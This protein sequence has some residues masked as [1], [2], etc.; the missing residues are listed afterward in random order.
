MPIYKMEGKKDGKQKY[1]VRI[2]YIDREGKSKQ[3]DRVAYGKEEAKELER[4]LNR[5]LKEETVKKI[6]L[7]ELTGEFLNVKKYE[8]RESS[9]DKMKRRLEYYVIPTLGDYRIDKLNTPILQKWKTT[10]EEMKT[11]T[12]KPL[13]LRTKQS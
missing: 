12:G 9:L 5:D 4:K 1:R 10:V 11:S 7:K 13:S 2:N 6:T 3:L 8:V